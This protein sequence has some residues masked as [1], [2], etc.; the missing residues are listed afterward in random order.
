[1]IRKVLSTSSCGLDDFDIPHDIELIRLHIMINGVE[2][3]DGRDINRDRLKHIMLNIA[4]S[5]VKTSPA[6][7]ENVALKLLAL[8][9]QGIREVFIT[10]LS[11]QMS[12]SYK[13]IK[14]VAD[15]FADRMQIYVYDCKDLNVCE[16]MLALEADMMKNQVASMDEIATRLDALRSNHRMLFTVDN[17]KYLIKNKKL[18]AQAG[19]FANLFNIKPVLSVNKE[20]EIVPINRIR[21]IERTYHYIIDE[22]ERMLVENSGNMGNVFAYILS[23]GDKK[24][25]VEF[26]ALLKKRL[27]IDHLPVLPVSSIS[28]ANHGP[29]G[30]GLC[31]FKDNIPLAKSFYTEV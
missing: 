29:S 9:Q 7:K 25:V 12:D 13:I 5:P 1:M 20:G 31:Y 23:S 3:I 6:T 2:F 26:S 19:F 30:V 10:T 4:T 17:L 24:M 28:M 18:T 27:G 11:S 22:F 15:T 16:A 8:Y 21:K 14:E